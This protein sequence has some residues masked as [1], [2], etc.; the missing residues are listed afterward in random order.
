MQGDAHL[1]RAAGTQ[2]TYLPS[3]LSRVTSERF[4]R[5]A[6]AIA[7]VPRVI[8]RVIRAR[9]I[10]TSK[11]NETPY[12]LP[13]VTALTMSSNGRVEPVYSEFLLP[14]NFDASIH[15]HPLSADMNAEDYDLEPSLSKVRA[16]F[17]GIRAHHTVA[18][19]LYPPRCNFHRRS[20]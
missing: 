10:Q 11:I 20:W 7:A 15:V 16:Q 19:Q 8:D 4:D 5:T 6:G 1:R 9:A 3:Y 18:L 12:P 2:S 17:C 14:I 13:S